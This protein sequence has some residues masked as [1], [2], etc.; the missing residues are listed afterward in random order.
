MFSIANV[1]LKVT[2]LLALMVLLSSCAPGE[3]LVVQ[4]SVSMVPTIPPG[5]QITVQTVF[6]GRLQRWQ[7]LV[8]ELPGNTN[9]PSLSRLVGLPGERVKIVEGQILVDGLAVTNPVGIVYSGP[10]ADGSLDLYGVGREFI[11]PKGSYFLL[12]DNWLNA[13]DS[14]YVGAIPADAIL[15]KAKG[16]R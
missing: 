3:K 14:R 2:P 12:G 11:V 5:T 16:I 4:R 7:I 10:V 6:L 8:F 15:G 9:A 1:S 13:R